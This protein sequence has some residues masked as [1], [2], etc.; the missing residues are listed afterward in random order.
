MQLL[1]YAASIYQYKKNCKIFNWLI[2]YME[3]EWG[4]RV[5]GYVA[6]SPP[7]PAAPGCS[8]LRTRPAHQ[9]HLHLVVAFPTNICIKLVYAHQRHSFISGGCFPN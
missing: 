5:T 1:Q 6:S 9:R 2:T 8:T 3:P 4:S 7:P